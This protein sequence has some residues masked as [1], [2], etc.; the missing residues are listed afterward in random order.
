MEC[1]FRCKPL[2]AK[3]PHKF[4]REILDDLR[5]ECPNVKEGC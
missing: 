4:V 1:P 3:D 5:F 2:V